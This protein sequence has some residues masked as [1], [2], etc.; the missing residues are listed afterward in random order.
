MR[1]QKVTLSIIVILLLLSFGQAFAIREDVADSRELV[2]YTRD[3]TEIREVRTIDVLAGENSILLPMISPEIVAGSIK[4][5][6]T[7]PNGIETLATSFTK[8]NFDLNRYWGEKVGEIVDLVVDDSTTHNGYLRN[9]SDKFF[10]I[11]LI[12]QPG[13]LKKVKRSEVEICCFDNLPVG[14]ALEASILWSYKAKKAGKATIKI[15]YITDELGWKG[16]H[17]LELGK[18]DGVVTAGFVMSNR[19][20]ITI[21]YSKIVF[22]GGAIHMAGDRRRVDR[23][24]PKPGAQIGESDTKAGDFRRW[25]VEADGVLPNGHTA[26]MP[27]FDITTKNADKYYVYD[28]TIFDDRV[29]SHIG[30]PLSKSL[31]AGQVRIFEKVDGEMMFV[32]SDKIDDTPAGSEFDLNLGQ[33]FD[34]TAERNRMKEIGLDN[35]GTSQV[36]E[37]KLGNSGK[38]A[39]TVRVLERMFGEWTIASSIVDDV[40]IDPNVVDSRIARFD[41]TVKPGK[42]ATLTYEIQYAR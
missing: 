7:K 17:R 21:P 30:F 8:A 9:V 20:G 23:L 12:D 2:V 19:T 42:T 13:I 3:I 26:V 6:I 16:H 36:Y 34:I 15:S 1:F 10:L 32:G 41:V 37:V 35:G 24:N 5:E 18:S 11:E 28:A 33:V 40:N 22:V 39:V 31:P 25:V 4:L 38:K 29:S 27:L 14:M